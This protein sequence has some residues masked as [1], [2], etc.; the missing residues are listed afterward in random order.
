MIECDLCHEH[1]PDACERY[2]L[3][4]CES[5]ADELDYQASLTC[6]ERQAEDDAIALYVENGGKW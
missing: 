5:C 2:G 6:A 3:T 4:V 1:T